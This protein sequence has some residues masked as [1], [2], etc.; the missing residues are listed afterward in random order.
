MASNQARL[1]QRPFQSRDPRAVAGIDGEDQPVEKAAAV[2]RRSVEQAV[3]GG[4]QPDH[5]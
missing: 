4:R 3:H 1:A 2:S 5:A